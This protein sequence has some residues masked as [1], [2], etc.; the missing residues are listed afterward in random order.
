MSALTAL[1]E[2]AR[3]RVA[4]ARRREGEDE[5]LARARARGPARDVWARLRA[6]PRPALVAE[7]KRA[8]P[9]AGAIA[10][11]ADPVRTARAYARAGAAMVSVLT[12]PTAFGGRLE[13]LERV[14]A[15]VDL[16]VLQKDFVVDPYQIVQARA[17]GADAVLLIVALVGRALGDLMAQARALGM[18]ALVE[19]HTAEE[20]A[21][22]VEAGARLIGVNNRDLATLRVD[23]KTALSLIPLVPTDRFAL[24]ES[25]LVSPADVRRAVRAGADGVLVGEYLMRSAAPEAAARALRQAG[26]TYVKVCGVIRREDAQQAV[27]AGADAVGFV[28]APS[29]RRV[30]AGTARALGEGLEAER[31]GVFAS[32]PLPEV[33]ETARRAGL[34]GV[35]LH[36]ADWQPEEVRALAREGL[37]VLA[38]VAPGPDAVERAR[39]ALAAGALP[40][41]D[42]R[43]G[44]RPDGRGGH[45]DMAQAARL[46]AG[47]RRLVLAGGL[48]PDNV[49]AAVAAVDPYGVDVS[50]GVEE[51]RPG[52]KDAARVRAFVAAARRHWRES[53]EGWEKA[54]AGGR[55]EGDG[56]AAG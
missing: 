36:D 48:D 8:S 11:H 41:V 22:A 35:Q 25:G 30:D 17:A 53:A 46:G 23:T 9:S 20:V 55:E 4:E 44:A 49:A 14:R 12:E 21:F 5:L 2:A 47:V 19:A 31:V 43:L 15:A 42:A 34:T 26:R 6:A 1:G 52:W 27:E 3:A 54:A 32:T 56:Y 7:F 29:P 28:F 39:A 40:L 50:S 37:D 16:P 33:V 51:G 13:D 38:A 45:L 24:A 18:E 10:A